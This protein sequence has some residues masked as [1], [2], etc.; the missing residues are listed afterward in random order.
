MIVEL[1]GLV[2]VR[3]NVPLL[4]VIVPNCGG[5]TDPTVTVTDAA[6]SFGLGSEVTEL[7]MAESVTEP[8]AVGYRVSVRV[9]PAP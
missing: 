4:V 7:T 1:A 5:C 3:W 9:A 8:M 6:L 2:I